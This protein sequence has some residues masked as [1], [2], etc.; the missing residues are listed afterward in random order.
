[1]RKPAMMA[2]PKTFDFGALV[3]AIREAD[4]HLAAQAGKAININLT[5]RNWLIGCYIR[6]YEQNGLDRAQYGESLL[7]TLSQRLAEAGLNGMAARSLRLYRQFYL[8]YPEI[9]Q[10]VSARSRAEAAPV[11]E[12]TVSAKLEVPADRLVNSLSLSHFAE[13]IAIDDALKRTFYEIE[14]MRGNWS[15]DLPSGLSGS[16]CRFYCLAQRMV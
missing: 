15:V 9:W 2:K 6:E 8:A 13:L 1:M 14:C 5:L 3:A 10:S 4:A 12:R 7:A 11:I 16:L